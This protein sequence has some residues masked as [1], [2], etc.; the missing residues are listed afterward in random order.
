MGTILFCL[1]HND[2]VDFF[3]FLGLMLFSSIHFYYSMDAWNWLNSSKKTTHTRRGKWNT[4]AKIR[5]RVMEEW[6]KKRN[7]KQCERNI[8]WMKK[9]RDLKHI[10]NSVIVANNFCYNDMQWSLYMFCAW[11][12]PLFIISLFF[13]SIRI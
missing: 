8:C 3:L 13:F 6:K 11:L 9:R 7:M 4:I 5:I 2:M 10:T 1:N 12:L